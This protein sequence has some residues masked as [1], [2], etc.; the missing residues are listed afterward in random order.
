MKITKINVDQNILKPKE[1]FINDVL[2]GLSKTPKSIPAKYFYDDNG[3]VL[4][5]KITKEKDY[6]LTKAEYLILEKNQSKIPKLITNLGE[7]NIIELGVG[8]GHKSKLI[9]DAFLSRNIK[10]N[11]YPIDIS[12]QA[13]VLLEQN[14]SQ[15]PLLNTQ[16]IIAD[17]F[18]GISYISSIS[19][20]PQLVLFLGSNIGNL[21]S[22]ERT[23]FIARLWQNLKAND[24]VLIGF[25]QKKDI[26]M[27]N[28]AYN[29][30]RGITKEFN[31]NLLR[32][33][34]SE[35]GANFNIEKF[36]HYGF[37]N[38]ILGAMESHLI[39]NAAQ[40][41][42]IKALKR[43]FHFDKFEPIHLEYSFKFTSRD[44]ESLCVNS[45][46]SLVRNFLDD[47]DFYCN[48]LWRVIKE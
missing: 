4:F 45:G 36:M 3:S 10:T 48:S 25:D 40:S 47:Q 33:M 34:N 30:S 32:R 35:L 5:Q 28:R 8:D 21:N 39:S 6:Y 11:Y 20:N 14:L 18:A 41:V 31:L 7:I 29:D 37:Y 16:G 43:H 46:Y 22:H 24:Y 42:Y 9:I 12:S 1:D 19:N 44:I 17:Y 15:S 13:M 26:S 38:P 27:L 2:V 23:S